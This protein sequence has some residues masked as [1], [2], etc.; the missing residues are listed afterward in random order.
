MPQERKTDKKSKIDIRVRMPRYP[1]TL[2]SPDELLDLL[3]L[4]PE[5]VMK[6][7]K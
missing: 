5:R 1:L 6:L 3:I 7:I 4:L 2:I